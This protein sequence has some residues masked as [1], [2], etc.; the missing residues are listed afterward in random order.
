M[1]K[2][3]IDHLDIRQMTRVVYDTGEFS[4]IIMVGLGCGHPIPIAIPPYMISFDVVLV[5]PCF[6]CRVIEP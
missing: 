4:H 3:G 5:T 1:I 6:G 2:K